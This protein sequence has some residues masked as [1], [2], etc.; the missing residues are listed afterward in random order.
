MKKVVL[1][2]SVIALMLGACDNINK[3]KQTATE[4]VEQVQQE[5]E[6]A[7]KE[8]EQKVQEVV[9]GIEV[10]KFGSEDFQKLADEYANYLKESAE[11]VKSGSTQKIQELQAKASEWQTK[12]QE[13]ASKLTPEDVTKLSEWNKKLSELKNEE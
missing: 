12:M 6:K 10:P 11:A 4:V 3:V 13:A 7:V 8:V 9:S 1:S 5:T 2:V